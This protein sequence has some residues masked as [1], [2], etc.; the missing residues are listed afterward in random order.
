MPDL[1]EPL[2]VRVRRVR[3]A[4]RRP[5][6]SAVGTEA[7]REVLLLEVPGSAGSGWGECP[8]LSDPTYA[9]E[10]TEDA[11][12]ALTEPGGRPGPTATAA[13]RDAKLDAA[14]VASGDRFGRPG[15]RLPRTTVA[16][17]DVPLDELD[18]DAPLKLKITPAHLGRLRAAREHWPHRSIMAD[19]NGSF[20]RASELVET[21]AEVGLTYL[22]QPFRRDDLA[23]HAELRRMD[24][25]PVALDESIR[26]V[27]DLR[28]AAAI[29]ALDVL[30]VKPS[31]VGGVRAAVELLDA[32]ADLGVRCFVGG[33]LE[34]GIGRSAALR[35]ASD[36]RCVLPTDLGPS[37]HYF[38]EDLCEPVEG[39]DGTVVVPGGPGLGRR[40]DPERLEKATVEVAPLRCRI[41]PA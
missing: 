24:P 23:T 16:G 2:T 28:A 5:H 21:L 12:I 31:R 27:A 39:D 6:R 36:P 4:L 9:G 41:T 25:T 19:A 26:S 18:G 13:L 7:V 33:M 30:S 37:D 8:T 22:E 40:P 3:L 11:W 20:D 14:L 32:A 15:V 1:A 29:G 38:L 35:V 34:T 10:T 17:L